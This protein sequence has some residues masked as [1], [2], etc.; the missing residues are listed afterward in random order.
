M[1]KTDCKYIVVGGGGYLGSKLFSAMVEEQVVRTS[2][3]GGNGFLSLNLLKPYDFDF[4][5]INRHDVV[6][7]TSA[8]SAP[9]VCSNDFEFAWAVNVDGTAK[10]IERVID[11]GGRV[12]F[13]SSDTVYGESDQAIDEY[14]LV[15]PAGN[16]AQMKAAVE[17]TFLGCAAFKSIR[18]SY[19]FSKYDKFAK[20]LSGC[21]N[22]KQHAEVF[23]PFYRA[24]IHRDDVVDGV[25]NLAKC[26][27]EC[28]EGVINFGGPELLSRV[29]MA[30]C[31]KDK[32]MHD[33]QL[34]IVEPPQYFFDNRPR[35]INMQSPVLNFLLKRR[36]RS[37]D[38]AVR[39]EFDL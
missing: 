5:I 14:G 22:S 7:L 38:E 30:L 26:W 36:P 8:I 32:A 13:F 6:F 1:I 18:L 9:D 2:T 28:V 33:L 31:L 25:L 24:V 17:K 19:V 37:F 15:N 39:I 34:K 16:Y 4:E 11:R 23:H 10:F 27:S 21:C 29:D 3:Q 35:V 12:I 20:Y